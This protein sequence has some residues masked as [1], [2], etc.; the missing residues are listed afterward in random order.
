VV[1]SYENILFLAFIWKRMDVIL[2]QRSAVVD[3]A[4]E[5]PVEVE[6][7]QRAPSQEL[8]PQ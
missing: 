5:D 6:A 8:H 4:P 1:K 3:N 2:H 7:V